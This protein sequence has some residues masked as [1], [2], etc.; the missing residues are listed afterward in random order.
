MCKKWFASISMVAYLCWP[1]LLL[2]ETSF[3][4]GMGTP[5]GILGVNVDFEISKKMDFTLGF[6]GTIFTGSGKAI[7][8]RYY[9]NPEKSRLRYSL[10]YGTNFFIHEDD[11]IF[12]GDS[13]SYEGFNISMGWGSKSNDSGWDFDLILKLTSEAEDRIKELQDLGDTIDDADIP[14]LSFSLGYHWN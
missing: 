10:I 7:G 3:G 6:G 14:S 11:C 5:Y 13:A 4:V 9:P 2:A 8:I 1:N 12:C